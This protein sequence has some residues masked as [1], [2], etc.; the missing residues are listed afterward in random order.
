MVR[1]LYRWTTPTNSVIRCDAHRL[2]STLTNVWRPTVVRHQWVHWWCQAHCYSS[3]ASIYATQMQKVYLCQWNYNRWFVIIIIGIT[4]NL[5]GHESIVFQ[6]Q[7]REKMLRSV[8]SS[9]MGFPV[10][11]KQCHQFLWS[12]WLH[13]YSPSNLIS[14]GTVH[15]LFYKVWNC[16]P[17]ELYQ[18]SVGD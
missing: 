1:G 8:A 5:H 3:L 10:R 4:W 6:K 18:M 9:R 16:M 2:L 14:N 17:F 12:M 13:D 15:I 11:K 7:A